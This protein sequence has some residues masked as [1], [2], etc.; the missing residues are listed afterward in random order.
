MRR[1]EPVPLAVGEEPTALDGLPPRPLGMPGEPKGKPKHQRRGG[2]ERF[3]QLNAFADFTLAA[4]D[5]NELAV[6]LLL[7]RDA[8][9][10]IARTSQRNLA[11]RAGACERT[12]RRAVNR[13]VGRGL[14]D[15]V[16]RGR[17]LTGPSAYRVHALPPDRS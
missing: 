12:V 10:G 17:L 13:L 4:L 1:G 3:R 11:R 14:L 5:R 7:F 2:G 9:D 16:R 15:V 6:W 8:R